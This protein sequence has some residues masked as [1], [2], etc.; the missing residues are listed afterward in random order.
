MIELRPH[1]PNL[2]DS[3]TRHEAVPSSSFLRRQSTANSLFRYL[4]V[5]LFES[6]LLSKFV[7]SFDE[8]SCKFSRHGAPCLEFYNTCISVLHI[9]FKSLQDIMKLT[10]TCYFY[11]G[12]E[13]W[14]NFH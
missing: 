5:I 11:V 9:M 12:C 1:L 6:I 14:P 3:A 13:V 7:S 2:N 8:N 10:S 4:Y